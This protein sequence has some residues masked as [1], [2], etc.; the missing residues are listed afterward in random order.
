MLAGETRTSIT[1]IDSQAKEISVARED[2]EDLIA[3]R[4]SVMPEGFEKQLTEKEL[5]DLLEFLT[6]KGPYIPLPLDKFATA[7][8]TK[9]LFSNGDSGPDRMVFPDWKPKVFEGIPFVLTDP[10]GKSQPNIIL[11]YGPY[12]PLPPK[13]PKTVAIP[14]GI[15]ATA[16]HMLSGVGGWSH[17][18]NTEKTAS[19][20]VRLTYEDG[21]KE[22]HE[23]LNAV[24][25][26]DYIR[27]V[28][29][30]GS[31]FAYQLGGQQIR[32]LKVSPKRADVIEKIELVKGP[33]NT[34]PIVMALTLQRPRD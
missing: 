9:G 7:V 10:V 1:I 33:D 28:D 14:C 25:F 30:P 22:D 15:S 12:G 29:V 23:L 18:Y 32:Y 4:K 31:K 27:R 5:T 24:H 11:L 17:P 16:I 21:Q 3:S 13:M 26:A 19:M 20:I 8:S 2:I 6:D 34:A